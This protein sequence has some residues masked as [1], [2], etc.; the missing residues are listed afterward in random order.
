[1]VILNSMSMGG[2]SSSA[3]AP[4]GDS[5]D[6]QPVDVM[7]LPLPADRSPK[8][9]SPE[10]SE[11]KRKKFQIKNLLT[12]TAEL[13]G[14]STGDHAMPTPESADATAQPPIVPAKERSH[15]LIF[16]AS[17]ALCCLCL[18]QKSISRIC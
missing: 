17:I 5:T 8:Q 1:M 2:H 7:A 11:E 4:V 18:C 15:F 12:Q 6:T 10:T 9:M 16:C 14:D 13:P 3:G